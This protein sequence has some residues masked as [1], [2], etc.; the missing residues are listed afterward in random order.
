MYKNNGTGIITLD[1]NGSETIDGQTTLILNPGESVII[2]CT[3]SAFVVLARYETVGYVTT[4]EPS[5]VNGD[6][7]IMPYAPFAGE[8][9]QNG[10]KTSAGSLTTTPKINGAAITGGGT[11]I[12]TSFSSTT[13]SSS[14][15]FV[16]GDALTETISS[17][18][19]A[20]KYIS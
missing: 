11:S 13:R 17:V 3:G 14:N 2:E 16:R 15:T 6:I 10:G 19:S 8:V 20:Q 12:T 18:S 4:S 7:T 1:P 9:L 5:P